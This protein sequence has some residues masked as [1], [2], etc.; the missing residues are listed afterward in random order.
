MKKF[1]TRVNA[2]ARMRKKKGVAK[3][4]KCP[5]GGKLRKCGFCTKRVDKCICEVGEAPVGK[6]LKKQS[7]SFCKFVS[8]DNRRRFYGDCLDV[9]FVCN[10]CADFLVEG[11]S[12]ACAVMAIFMFRFFN[13]VS[14]W[15]C[16]E[17][18][19]D[20]K[21]RSPNF[22]NIEEA[23]R[24]H[25]E[26]LQK[27]FAIPVTV[28]DEEGQYVG[29]DLVENAVWTFRSVW[30]HAAF[31]KLVRILEGGVKDVGAYGNL[32]KA[33]EELRE[34]FTG[35]CGTYRFKN[36]LDMWV[37]IGMVWKDAINWWP[38]AQGSGTFQ[39]L[40]ILYGKSLPSEEAASG[41]L[42]HLYMVFWS[43]GA[44]RT[45]SD[46]IGTLG[47]N[48]CGWHRSKKKVKYG[49]S[50]VSGLDRAIA[51][52]EKEILLLRARMNLWEVPPRLQALLKATAS[53]KPSNKF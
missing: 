5:S 9:A 49:N 3:R 52:E 29:A 16:I 11:G 41:C 43:E 53:G 25:E 17:E 36:N 4:R 27:A 32:R 13:R 2:S 22:E 28:W 24:D 8:E 47:L 44:F 14:T 12:V 37:H 48:L 15:T 18:G 31:R 21:R 39:A 42:Q 46:S 23:L 7:A 33:W 30:R 50:T 1:D 40:E 20:V 38:V 26:S 10:W 6:L 45:R 34:S 19:F 35:A 51:Q